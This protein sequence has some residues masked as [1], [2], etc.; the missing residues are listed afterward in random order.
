MLSAA[1]DPEDK[2]I[3][4]II[5]QPGNFEAFYPREMNGISNSAARAAH[6]HGSF[7]QYRNPGELRELS[8]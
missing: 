1:Y 2:E 3:E 4:S 6:N 7:F 8:M 5:P